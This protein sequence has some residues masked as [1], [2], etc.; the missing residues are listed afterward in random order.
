MCFFANVCNVQCAMCIIRSLFC[1]LHC[2]LPK[3]F[4]KNEYFVQNNNHLGNLVRSIEI[5][6]TTLFEIEN[7]NKSQ[8]L[9]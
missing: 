8:I 7:L 6:V 9:Y 3:A 4:R 2:S 1:S 5:F